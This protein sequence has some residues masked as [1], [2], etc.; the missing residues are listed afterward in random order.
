MTTIPG[1]PHADR[2]SD[3]PASLLPATVIVAIIAA[4]LGTVGCAV[5][6]FHVTGRDWWVLLRDPAAAFEFAPYAGLFSHLGVLA[7]TV[8]GAISVFAALV[9]PCSGREKQVLLSAGLLSLWL[10]VDDLFMLHEALLPRLIGLPEAMTLGVYVALGLGLLG[11]IG[12]VVLTRRYLG[13]WASGGFLAAMLATDL[14]FEVATSASLLI[15]EAAKVCGFMLWA[16][17]WIAEAR[18]ALCGEIGRE[19]HPG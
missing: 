16:A 1:T 17:F 14:T 9:L 6:L 10:A 8:S 7:M 12:P 11:L 2:A 18:T 4:V 13:L 19:P 5:A 15:E 3:T